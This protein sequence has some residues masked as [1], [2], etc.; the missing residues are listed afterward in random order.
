MGNT[1]SYMQG[2]CGKLKTY[3]IRFSLIIHVMRLYCEESTDELI[4][5]QSANAA[6]VLADY[7]L[8]M[9]KRVHNLIC[10]QPVDE[11]HQQL[12]DMLDSEFTTADA[13]S[14]GNSLNL[15]ESTVKRFLR[16]GVGVYLRKDR[17]G[18]Y[19]KTE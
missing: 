11:V 9:D 5:K 13:V 19:I 6:C 12:F 3:V 15:S 17:H 2:V 8:E 7:F 10:N 14:V 4:D 16:N 18:V 1:D